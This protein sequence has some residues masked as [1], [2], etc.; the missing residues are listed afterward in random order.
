[1]N[2]FYDTN[3]EEQ[4]TQVNINYS[5]S[6]VDIYTSRKMTFDRLK[7]KLG[8]PDDTYCI[9]GKVT[10]GRWKVPFSEKRKLTSILS[11]PL[12]IGNIK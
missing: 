2:K 7:F 3:Y 9:S 8:D 6:M 5:D 12:L 11:R 10:G 1:M 4:E